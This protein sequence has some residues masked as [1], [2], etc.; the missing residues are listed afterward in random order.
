[1]AGPKLTLLIALA[2]ALSACGSSRGNG[3]RSSVTVALPPAR[4]AIARP[5]FSNEPADRVEQPGDESAAKGASDL[6]DR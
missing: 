6:L 5:G 3:A 4:P 2:F 1:M